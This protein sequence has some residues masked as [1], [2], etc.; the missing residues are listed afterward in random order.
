MDALKSLPRW[1]ALLQQL[2]ANLEMVS[3]MRVRRP[4]KVIVTEYPPLGVGVFPILI[5]CGTHL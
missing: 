2:A 4:T 3:R 1:Q 5:A